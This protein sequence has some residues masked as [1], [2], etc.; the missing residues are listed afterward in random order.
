MFW[1]AGR[2]EPSRGP[3]VARGQRAWGACLRGRQSLHTGYSSSSQ[4][5]RKIMKTT[6]KKTIWVEYLIRGYARVSNYFWGVQRG[7]HFD[8][9]VRQYQK[10][11]NPCSLEKHKIQWALQNWNIDNFIVLLLWSNRPRLI[12]VVL[13]FSLF[14]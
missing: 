11:E 6:Q 7:V 5:V 4:G 14:A 12:N 3:H 9:G 13:V 8:L 2:I 10:V 1:K